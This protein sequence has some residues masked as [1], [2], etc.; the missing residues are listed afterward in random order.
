M[1]KYK[2]IEKIK[3]KIISHRDKIEENEKRI[4]VSKHP[5]AGTSDSIHLKASN[6]KENSLMMKTLVVFG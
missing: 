4:S 5:K 6:R 2:S 3:A 1:R